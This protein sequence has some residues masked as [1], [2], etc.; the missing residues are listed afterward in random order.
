VAGHHEAVLPCSLQ[1]RPH[2]LT[3]MFGWVISCDRLLFLG[4]SCKLSRVQDCPQYP[5]HGLR[6]EQ[7]LL[8]YDMCDHTPPTEARRQD[9][10]VSVAPA[11]GRE[12]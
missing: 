8:A 4:L 11:I 1:S 12:H 5:G 9:N 10:M 7:M 6:R 2:S 3:A